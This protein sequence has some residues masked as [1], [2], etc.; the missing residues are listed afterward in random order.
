MME[1]VSQARPG[2]RKNTLGTVQNN[3]FQRGRLKPPNSSY[4]SIKV[5]GFKDFLFSIMYGI[6][7]V[8]HD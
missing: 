6:I 3:I 5:G 8:N 4:G 2:R 1:G 7:L